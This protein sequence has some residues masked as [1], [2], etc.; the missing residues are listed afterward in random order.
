[1]AG[2]SRFVRANYQF[3]QFLPL[4]K[5]LTL[6][7][8]SDLGYGKGLDGRPYPVFKNFFVGG[9]GSVRGYQQSSI[10]QTTPGVN[11]LVPFYLGGAKKVV[12]NLEAIGPFPGAG[13]DKTLRAFGFFD[14]GYAY[15]ESESV[16]L[17][18]LRKSYGVGLSWISPM[19]PLRFTYGVPISP[20]SGDRIQKFQFQIGTS[21]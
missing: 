12:F 15:Q 18:Q 14:A 13:N 7:F 3:Q 6:A 5:K 9:L 10:G 8:N 19:G 2:D 1:V 17:A 21:F 4:N 11:N 20:R 16:D